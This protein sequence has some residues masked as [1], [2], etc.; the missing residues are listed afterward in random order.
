MFEAIC[1]VIILFLLLGTC[2][3][4][5]PCSRGIC[6]LITAAFRSTLVSGITQIWRMVA[7]TVL[8]LGICQSSACAHLFLPISL[9]AVRAQNPVLP[10][11]RAL[12]S[13][14]APSMHF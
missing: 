1:Q 4:N 3:L 8:H 12:A 2:M 7:F 14:G 10:S 11:A 13:T 6:N 9:P 5:C